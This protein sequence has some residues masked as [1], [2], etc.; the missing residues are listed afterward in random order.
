MTTQLRSRTNTVWPTLAQPPTGPRTAISAYVAEK[1]FRAGVG[2]LDVTVRIVSRAGVETI[3]MGGPVLTIRRPDEFFARLGRGVL[4]GF[5]EAYL[6]GA[7]DADDLVSVLSV[8]AAELPTLVPESLQ[9]SGGDP[10]GSSRRHGTDRSV[11]GGVPADPGRPLGPGR[12][13]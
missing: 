12:A 7:W 6:T 8:M 10:S 2:R 3:G 5:G 13:R 11:R 1:L 4:I 9:R